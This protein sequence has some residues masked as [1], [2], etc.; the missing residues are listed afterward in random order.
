MDLIPYVTR[1]QQISDT[2]FALIQYETAPRLVITFSDK[3]NFTDAMSGVYWRDVD[4]GS[5]ELKDDT[6]KESLEVVATMFT[7]YGRANAQRIL[8]VFASDDDS[9]SSEDLLE[10]D[11]K[12]RGAG[13]KVIP[14]VI[15]APSDKDKFVEIHPKKKP[16]FVIERGRISPDNADPISD[17]I[18][19]GS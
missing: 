14:V 19:K 12:L 4:G 3:D 11:E 17:E 10:A 18:F 1:K 9:T 6:L 5:G 8:V 16:P 2:K 15:T 7:K 13:I